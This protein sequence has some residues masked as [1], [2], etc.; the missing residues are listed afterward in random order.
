MDNKTKANF[1]A[2]NADPGKVTHV[3][4]CGMHVLTMKIDERRNEI[5]FE[6]SIKAVSCHDSKKA[7]SRCNNWY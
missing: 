7:Y 6:E 1:A 3:K 4:S 5:I 2:A